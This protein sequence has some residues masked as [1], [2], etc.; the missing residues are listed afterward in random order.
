MTVVLVALVVLVVVA[1][2]LQV[3][4]AVII[5]IMEAV[6]LAA[7]LQ[8]ENCKGVFTF[9][10]HFNYMLASINSISKDFFIVK[11]LLNKG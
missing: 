9:I 11:E 7:I 8:A 1:M 2:V 6:V 3:V 4:V 5:V 10:Q